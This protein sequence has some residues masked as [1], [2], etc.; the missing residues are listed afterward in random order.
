MHRQLP[1]LLILTSSNSFPTGESPKPLVASSDPVTMQRAKK[2]FIST[3]SILMITVGAQGWTE[4]RLSSF[5]PFLVLEIVLFSSLE[6]TLLETP[7]GLMQYSRLRH[8]KWPFLRRL[9]V[10][11][12]RRQQKVKKNL[13]AQA[14]DCWQHMEVKSRK[15]TLLRGSAATNQPG[16][17]RSFT[18]RKVL[19]RLGWVVGDQPSELL[20][21][22]KARIVI[23]GFSLGVVS[24]HS[25]F[26]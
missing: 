16:K 1:I 15:L 4:S 20:A 6:C 11:L 23:P 26:I 3:L 17:V 7:Q 18:D 14:S 13:F 12:D 19:Q 25:N 22:T 5:F 21:L 24:C 8:P 10:A 2:C 9:T